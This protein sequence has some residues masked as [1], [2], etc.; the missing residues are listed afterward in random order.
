[1]R[2]EVVRRFPTRDKIPGSTSERLSARARALAPARYGAT[3]IVLTCLSQI[4]TQVGLARR[5]GT[6]RSRNKMRRNDPHS[7][8]VG[9]PRTENAVSRVVPRRAAAF[10][11]VTKERPG[12]NEGKKNS[13][14][15][16]SVSLSPWSCRRCLSRFLLAFFI[17]SPS[18]ARDYRH[19]VSLCAR[20]LDIVYSRVSVSVRGEAKAAG[21]RGSREIFHSHRRS[22]LFFTVFRRRER[23]GNALD[24]IASMNACGAVNYFISLLAHILSNTR[25]PVRLL[26]HASDGKLSRLDQRIPLISR[27]TRVTGNTAMRSLSVAFLEAFLLESREL[28][29][30]KKDFVAYCVITHAL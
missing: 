23:P 8:H 21:S 1:M 25:H 24:I 18:L 27:T 11:V 9:E 29:K 14:P 17:T 28:K 10:F 3:G 16:P 15:R 26:T 13:P 7:V 6:K 19:R 4:L 5:P 22:C 20:S 12:R 30:K 2:R